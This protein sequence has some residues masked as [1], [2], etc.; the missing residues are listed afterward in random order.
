MQV[1]RHVDGADAE[2]QLNQLPA[3][4][5]AGG[6]ARPLQGRAEHDVR[7]Q[8][9]VRVRPGLPARVGRPGAHVHGGEIMDRVGP[10]VRRHLVPAARR[11]LVRHVHRRQLHG[12]VE[13]HVR[14]RARVPAERERESEVSR[15]RDVDGHGPAVPPH[16]VRQAGRGKIR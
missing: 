5:G 12:R 16:R 2:M 9:R 13:R 1:R 15:E 11:H 10:H 4:G 14:V 6:R 7:R 8:D 3:S